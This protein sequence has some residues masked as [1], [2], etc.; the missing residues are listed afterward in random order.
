MN[1]EKIK[2]LPNIIFQFIR[3]HIVFDVF[4]GSLT[5]FSIWYQT[6]YDSSNKDIE[7]KL[8]HVI[9]ITEKQQL[10]NERMQKIE[11]EHPNDS[12]SILLKRETE[13]IEY[14][15]TVQK[16]M[17]RY[18]SKFTKIDEIEYAYDDIIDLL[19]VDDE[20][21]K[22]A[23]ECVSSLQDDKIV[24]IYTALERNKYIPVNKLAKEILALSYE[25]R[26]EHY[27]VKNDI[28]YHTSQYKTKEEQNQYM[29][30]R[31]AESFSS[32]LYQKWIE[33][34]NDYF[35]EY[36]EFLNILIR[37]RNIAQ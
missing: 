24:F 30:K 1:L 36:Y 5:C 27:K 18:I 14:A 33:K 29:K 10:V 19:N 21:T 11:I 7:D 26:I 37:Q 8:I 34:Q 15:L 12:I 25:W 3:N 28:L 23:I 16:K 13:R 35:M 6:C 2:K 20:A 31:I 22:A 17:Y 32:D 9:Q 4:V